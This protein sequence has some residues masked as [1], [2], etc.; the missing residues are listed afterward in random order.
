MTCRTR[1]TL[2]LLLSLFALPVAG[3]HAAAH[4]TVDAAASTA[5]A[6]D[7]GFLAEV[8]AAGEQSDRGDSLGASLPSN[9]CLPIHASH[10]WM[11]QR[12]DV[13][14]A[15]ARVAG[16]QRQDALAAQRLDTALSIHPGNATARFLLASGQL[17]D[18]E[19]EAS[20]RNIIRAIDDTDGVPDLHKDM[21][22]QLDLLLKDT[23][24]TRLDL[25]QALFDR[26]WKNDDIDPAALWVTLAT[27]QVEAGQRDKV[28]ATLERIDQP[29]ALITLRS[30]KRFDR[31]LPR[32]DPASIRWHRRNGISTACACR[33]CWRRR[34]MRWPWSW[35]MRCWWP[36]S[37]RK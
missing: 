22:W 32:T 19:V 35:P 28:R 20:A 16:L 4:D 25:L 15:A 13:W 23:P 36:A 1:H 7:A 10:S 11:T 18:N 31:Y 9:A 12:S 2:A 3:A 8:A 33:A 27:L 5:P 29:L 37:R 14:L 26:N 30:D 21:V 17:V 34:W 24:A 6:A